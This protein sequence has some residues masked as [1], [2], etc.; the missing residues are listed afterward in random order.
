MFP[1]NEGVFSIHFLP[2]IPRMTQG[3][4]LCILFATVERAAADGDAGCSRLP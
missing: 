2:V 4:D 3:R 1:L